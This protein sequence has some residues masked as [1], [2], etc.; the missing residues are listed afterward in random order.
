MKEKPSG[1]SLLD[2]PGTKHTSL[3][4]ATASMS[5]YKD[6]A[7]A[8]LFFRDDFSSIFAWFLFNSGKTCGK[9]DRRKLNGEVS[10][11]STTGMSDELRIRA[12]LPSIPWC[13]RLIQC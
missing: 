5:L 6:S 2:M 12:I 10:D 9:I 13:N 8:R 4:S 7:E 11:I 3:T 1:T